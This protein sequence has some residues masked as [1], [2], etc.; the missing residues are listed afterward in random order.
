MCYRSL[1]LATEGLSATLESQRDL[2][3]FL[4]GKSS[5]LLNGKSAT[6]TC[7]FFKIPTVFNQLV[8]CNNSNNCAKDLS[9]ELLP[10]GHVFVNIHL[11]ASLTVLR[12][13]KAQVSKYQFS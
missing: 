12:T 10:I 5:T 6:V 13:F 1:H 11:G 8:C 2:Y 7:V 3:L 4:L 9:Q